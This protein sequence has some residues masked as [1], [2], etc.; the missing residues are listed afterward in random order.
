MFPLPPIGRMPGCGTSECGYIGDGYNIQPYPLMKGL[1][2][3]K[4]IM[5]LIVIGVI[6]AVVKIKQREA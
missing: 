1:T 4:L 3:K 6:V 2:L 5:A